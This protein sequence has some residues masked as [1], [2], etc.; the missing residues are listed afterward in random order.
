MLIFP[1]VA[2]ISIL[3]IIVYNYI[4]YMKITF[5]K[6][7]MRTRIEFF[8]CIFSISNKYFGDILIFTDS[9]LKVNIS[10]EK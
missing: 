3:V 4:K 5:I 10:S 9:F 1:I 2:V 6:R 7:K 8:N